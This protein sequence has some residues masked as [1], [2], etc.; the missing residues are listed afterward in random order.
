MIEVHDLVK[1]W[2]ERDA[3]SHVSFTVGQGDIVGFLG[4]NGAGKS[5]TMRMITGYLRPTSGEV[6]LGGTF[7][8]QDSKTVRA[9]IGY[10]PE[11]NPLYEDLRVRE[12]LDFRAALKGVPR[13]FRKKRIEQTLEAC[14][15]TEVADRI[16]G[17]CSKGFRQRVGLADALLANPPVLI[18]D[19]PTV[20]L[21]PGQVVHTRALIKQLAADH[22]VLLSTHILPE[23]EAICTR[24]LILHEGRLLFDGTVSD[25]HRDLSG[26]SRVICGFL[27]S[28]EA[29]QACL[30]HTT[31]IEDAAFLDEAEGVCRFR[32]SAPSGTAVREALFR[33]CAAQHV[34]LVELTPERVSLEEAFLFITTRESPVQVQA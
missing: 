11:N 9:S 5:T 8:S 1:R 31:G 17:T 20:G 23:V 4:P 29:G 14:E 33:E 28:R 3:V 25:L 21:D 2:G 7:V 32:V 30:A 34:P 15:V 26:S 22:T 16:I 18:L 10:L 6:R 27:S 13:A 19:E 24:A 12:Y